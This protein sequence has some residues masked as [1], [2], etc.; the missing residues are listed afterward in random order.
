MLSRK[1]VSI[2]F[3]LKLLSSFHIKD[4]AILLQHKLYFRSH[5]NYISTRSL[6]ILGLIHYFLHF[7]G[8]QIL[9]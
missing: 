7:F 6:N 1:T 8:L 5:I 2:N 4:V 3:D 9:L